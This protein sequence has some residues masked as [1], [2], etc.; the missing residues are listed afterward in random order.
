MPRIPPELRRGP[1]TVAEARAAGL[2]RNHLESAAW[3]RLRHGVYVWAGLPDDPLQLLAGLL[4]RLPAGAAF[5][6]LTAAWLHRLESRWPDRVSATAPNLPRSSGRA[7][8]RLRCAR[9]DGD[10][11]IRERLPVTS[12]ARTLYDL[13]AALPLVE[14]VAYADAALHA[15]KV[16]PAELE[17]RAEAT[18]GRKGARRF[19]RVL[20]LVE[21]A[22]ESPMETRL[23]LLLVLGGLPRPLA[24]ATL[25][26]HLGAAIGRVD[27]YYPDQRLAIEFDGEVHR[28]SLVSD[29]R[30]QN[31]IVGSG[32]TLLRF[33]GADVLGRPQAVVAEVRAALAAAVQTGRRWKLHTASASM[34]TSH[35]TAQAR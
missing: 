34:A 33:S 1:F 13:A 26:D 2:T 24:Q 22:A 21:P 19:R 3:R 16:S 15:G 8:V 20:N 14:A 17:A 27:L 23:R 6:E 28:D 10:V 5:S 25:R 18:A 31:R 32:C 7:G 4:L 30:R 35:S 12:A 29:L 11:V 9:L